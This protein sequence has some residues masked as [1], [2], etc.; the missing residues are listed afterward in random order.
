MAGAT[1]KYLRTMR[2]YLQMGT[3]IVRLV[4]WYKGQANPANPG[5]SLTCSFSVKRSTNPQPHECT[6]SVLGLSRA[7]RE[8]ILKAYETA[9]STAW[10]TRSE[11][12]L[13][14]IRVDAGY[15]DDVA[16]LFVGDLAP[17]GVKPEWSRPGHTMHLRALDGRIAWKGRFVNK[18]S[19]ANVDIKTIRQ[20]LAA[21]G[22]YMAGVESEQAFDKNFPNLVKKK[23]GFAGY[24]SGYA[25]FG[26]SREHNRSLCRTLGIAPFYQDGEVRYM[27][28][29][30]ALLDA[31]VVLSQERGGVL[32]SYQPLGLDRYR[33]RTLMEHRLRPGRQVHLRDDLGRPIGRGVYR[34]DSMHAFGG[35]RTQDYYVEADLLATALTPGG[36]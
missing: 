28:L 9:E 23:I 16:T 21:G 18:S 32:L 36:G 27:S 25:I 29:E 1:E 35:N 6:I 33:V 17:D 19:G 5:L 14:K 12:Q 20:V 10:S 24:E 4:D 26:E 13:G 15:G 31:A 30:A 7:R 34:V 22:D 11:L 8:G 2:V 3:T